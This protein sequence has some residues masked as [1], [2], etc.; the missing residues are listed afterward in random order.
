M[1][2]PRIYGS[3]AGN[4]QGHKE[5]PSKCI[6]SVLGNER[7][8]IAH[9]CDRKRGHG[10]DGLY[11]KQHDPEVAKARRAAIQKKYNDKWAEKQ[12]TWDLEKLRKVICDLAKEVVK[13]GM[14]SEEFI[15]SV[16]ELQ[17]SE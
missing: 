10:A 5:D 6:E 13:T 11:C 3:W 9:Q 16:K 14:I 2:K 12:K 7:G 1:D 17:Q 8:A 4:P 15:A